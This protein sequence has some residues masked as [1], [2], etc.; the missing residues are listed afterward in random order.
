[1]ATIRAFDLMQFVDRI[2]PSPKYLYF[3]QGEQQAVNSDYLGW[4]R[5]DQLLLG[6]LFSTIDKEVLGQV[7]HCES[8]LEVWSFLENLYSQQIVAHSFQLKQQL[9]SVKKNDLS[10]RM[11]C[12]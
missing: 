7:I 12:Q 8:A 2:A 6:W 10:R 11:I 1:M 9:R 4:I 5:S 3:D